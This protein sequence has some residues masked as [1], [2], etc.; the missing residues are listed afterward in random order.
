MLRLSY[1]RT[2]FRQVLYIAILHNIIFS[3]VTKRVIRNDSEFLIFELSIAAK[4]EADLYPISILVGLPYKMIPQTTI[5]YE[6]EAPTPFN[7]TKKIEPGFS[8]VNSQELQGL[9][10][11]TLRLSPL[12]DK[13]N[14]Y[15]RIQ[16]KIEYDTK[17][18][19]YRHPNSSEI[20]LLKNRIIN[21][22]IAKNWI[23]EKNKKVNRM[24]S[25][26]SGKWFQF[27]LSKDGISAIEFNILDSLIEDLDESDPR[28]FSIYMGAELGRPIN[29]SFNQPILENLTEISILITGEEDGKFDIND[30]I[31]FYGRGSSGFDL[32]DNGIEWKQNIYFNSNSCWLLI[33]EN[34]QLR[35]KRIEDAIQPIS[36][37]LIDYGI[38]SHHIE[39]DLINLQASGTEWVGNPIPSGGSQPIILDLPNP[40]SG[41]NISINARFRGHSLTETSLSNHQLSI[42]YG[43]VNGNQIGTLT[44]WTGNSSRQYS[45][46]TGS[47]DLNNGVNIFYIKN[48]SPDVNSYPYLDFFELHHGREL[49]FD[50]NFEFQ[51]PI[52][53]QDLRMSFSGQRPS[54]IRL[55]DISDPLN[56]VNLELD[57]EGFCNVSPQFINQN[58]FSLFTE[59]DMTLVSDLRPNYDHSLLTLRETN[60]QADYIIIGPDK[61]RDEAEDL[62][63]LRNPAIYASIE[64]IYLEYSAGN[65]DP[66]AI[67]SFIQWTQEMWIAPHPTCVL[68][69][70]ESGYDYRNITGQSTILIP[71]I[72]VQASRTYATDDL[73]VSIYGNIPEVATGRYPA[74][75]EQEVI[76]FVNK[77]VT[78]ETNPDYG[79]WRQKITLVADDAARPEPKHGSINTGKSHTLNSEQL[80]SVVPSSIQTNKIYMMEFPEVSDASAYGVV[81]P[82]ATDALFN[83]LNSGTAIISYIGH[84]S[85]Y[86][87]AQE[88]L[89]DLNRGDLNQINTGTKLPLWIVGTCSFGHFDDPITES[90][91]EELIRSPMNAASMVIS[92]S[93]PITVVGNERYTLEI[94]ETIFDN[95]SVSKEKIGII[96][97]SIKDGSSESQYFHLFGDPAMQLPMPF[98]T[99]ETLNISSDTLKT[100][101]SANYFGIQNSIP[102][103]GYG[104]VMLQDAPKTVTREYE[105]SSETYSL[106]YVLPG[107]TLFRGQFSFTGQTINGAIRIPEDI[108]YSDNQASLLIYIS[109]GENEASS[110]INNI[111]LSGGD[112]SDDNFGP[113]ISF[114]NEVGTK[115]EYGDHFDIDG[116][117]IIRLSD[118]LGINLT[119]ET[120]HE[121]IIDNLNTMNSSTATNDFLYDQNSIT[122]GTLIYS[123]NEQFIHINV[124][125][126]DSANNP[127]QKEIKL[128]GSND[129]G[130]RIYNAYNFPNPFINS[131]QFCFEITENVTL[132]VDV[133]SLGGRKIWS[134]NHL[135]LDAGFHTIE[136]NGNDAYN[137]EIANG[138]YIYRI[139]AIGNSS[140]VSHIGKCA[141]Y[142]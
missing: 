32:T 112:A 67:R 26:Q 105:I 77:I 48:I 83:A 134:S 127:S 81:K 36:G 55:W 2:M 39:S 47:L 109:D 124:K 135:N 114:E 78:I 86:Q 123:T 31:I 53:N 37:V 136:W 49:K 82:G 117:I 1:F 110:S 46:T 33:P 69:L 58:R 139:K 18:E 94:F 116:E 21:W 141:K 11:A 125:A 120:G 73:L 44:S 25:L 137:G 84:G 119:N 89:L 62:L 104:Y 16:V 14:Y 4:T 85:P 113:Q 19:N 35:G 60:L 10:T 52:S 131:T 93:R 40:K 138:V 29:D 5:S 133:Y 42:T 65:S 56:V 17:S 34:N 15:Q 72:Q 27:F 129:R 79:P 54:D 100:L 30:K 128:F 70:G 63:S 8:W 61:F 115:L 96:L 59:S 107:A 24:T 66:L 74:R 22:E 102:G 75:N 38:S 71:T 92:T 88:K 126:W 140:T 41:A 98:D 108:S 90:F 103:N 23:I 28:S 45:T 51:S 68:L 130:L 9:E 3:D 50:Q 101:E 20:E 57:N 97:Q 111:Y 6:N 122:T 99:L 142:Y 64:Q 13:K 87:L 106:T 95:N 132:K 43:S 80:A 121:I 7:T 118:P 91:S 76:D 12:I